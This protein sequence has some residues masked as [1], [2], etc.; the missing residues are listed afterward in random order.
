MVDQTPRDIR[1]F[2]TLQIA[3]ILVFVLHELAAPYDGILPTIVSALFELLLTLLVSRR[4]QNWAR[5]LIFILT[6][7]GSVLMAWDLTELLSIGYPALTIA[8]VVLQLAAVALLCTRQS[9]NWLK[10]RPAH[11]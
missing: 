10:R 6:L 7:L 4:R 3:S 1:I 9:S 2:E 5:W 11:S 8:V